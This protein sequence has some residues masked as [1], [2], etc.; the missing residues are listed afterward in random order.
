MRTLPRLTRNHSL[1]D[2][3]HRINSTTLTDPDPCP[4]H[5]PPG[6]YAFDR[7]FRGIAWLSA[8]LI[9]ALVVYII[10]EIGGKACRRSPNT[11][12]SFL[13]STTWNVQTR[14]FGILP[15]IWGTL[16]SSLLALMLGG[17][18]GVA[19]AIFL[20][21]DFLPSRLA[22]VF[23]TIIELLAAIP[24]VVFGLWGI[25]VLIPLLRP[26]P[27]WLHEESRLASRSSAPR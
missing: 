26:L 2:S 14:Q 18:F 12:S 19:I 3:W 17:V 13:T 15:E 27:N 25:Y 23:R 16:Y 6:D 4:A 21:Q 8:V 22:A 11:A 24:S 9:L 20:T 5:P 7:G 10:I 1:G